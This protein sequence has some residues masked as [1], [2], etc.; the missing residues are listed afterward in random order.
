MVYGDGVMQGHRSNGGKG[1]GWG[2]GVK[3]ERAGK[4]E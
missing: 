3:G 4:G 2:R 1:E